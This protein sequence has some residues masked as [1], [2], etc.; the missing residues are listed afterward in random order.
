MTWLAK[1]SRPIA[2]GGAAEGLAVVAQGLP[3]A[4]DGVDGRAEVVLADPADDLAELVVVEVGAEEHLVAVDGPAA[5]AD[6][7]AG[8]ADVG[9]LVL[10]ARVR[11]T[12]RVHAQRRV[13]LQRRRGSRGRD[14]RRGSR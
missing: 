14:R 5:D 6:L 3:R 9:D 7:G 13:A 2:A 1:A 4:D 10:G 12:R 11:A 8:Q